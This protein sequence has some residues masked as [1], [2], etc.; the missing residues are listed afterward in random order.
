MKVRRPD[1]SEVT[2]TNWQIADRF[3]NGYYLHRR[4]EEKRQWVLRL[5]PMS[6]SLMEHAFNQYLYSQTGEIFT[7]AVLLDPETPPPPSGP[8]TR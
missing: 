4:D 8:A 6:R 3:I 1:G 5:D 2:L 7:V